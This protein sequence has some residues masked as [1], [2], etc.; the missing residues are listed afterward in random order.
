MASLLPMPLVRSFRNESCIE[1]RA[2]VEH[3]IKYKL[4]KDKN[5]KYNLS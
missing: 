1:L 3:K 2:A 5:N 4:G